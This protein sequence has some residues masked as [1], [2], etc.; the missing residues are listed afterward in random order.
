MHC[1]VELP[2]QTFCHSA[3]PANGPYPRLLASSD[4]ERSLTTSER[5][6]VNQDK[7][8]VLRKNKNMKKIRGASKLHRCLSIVF[9]AFAYFIER[10][11]RNWLAYFEYF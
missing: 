7:K 10:P 3:G 2:R 8:K 1:I 9:L 5:N 6:P 4:R 11:S